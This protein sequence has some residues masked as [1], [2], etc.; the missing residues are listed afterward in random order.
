MW[1]LRERT[2]GAGLT[3][4]AD[5]SSR[6]ARFVVKERDRRRSSMDGRLLL[7]VFVH[8]AATQSPPRWCRPVA[9]KLAIGGMDAAVIVV[10][11]SLSQPGQAFDVETSR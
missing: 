8:A 5:S 10:L 11:P 4:F 2:H 3:E 1:R 7:E 6:S 9:R